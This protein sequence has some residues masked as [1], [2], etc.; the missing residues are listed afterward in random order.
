MDA[1]GRCRVLATAAM[2]FLLAGCAGRTAVEAPGL[3]DGPAGLDGMLAGSGNA[4]AP[5]W[6]V[7]QWWDHHWY[8]GPADTVGFVVKAIV[9]ENGTDG[10]RLATD[11]AVDAASH[12]AFY[13]HDQGVMSPTDW[14]VRDFGGAFQMPYYS[15]P[16]S[17][18]KTWRAQ[19]ENLDFALQRVS[20]QL[21]LTATAIDGT[22]GAFL[23]EARDEA[24]DLRGRWDYQP[25]IGWFSDY[26]LYQPGTQ[27]AEQYSI[28]MVHEAQG[29]GWTGT[30]H[31]AAAD[32]LLNTYRDF[33]PFAPSPPQAPAQFTLT[34]EHT[35]AFV[36]LFSYA[37]AGG[38]AHG[39]LVAPD[40]Q[41]WEASATT[42]PDGSPGPVQSQPFIFVPGVPGDWR[43]AFA[44]ADAAYAGGGCFAFGMR[45][46][47]ATL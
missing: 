34:A 42:L 5:T 28:R 7:G 33:S 20:R 31:L 16:L 12:A 18:G 26:R 1:P 41:H 25:A 4:T 44:A 19:E 36:V 47:A 10:Y 37:V 9:V 35:H 39:Q 23:I 43:F 15:F 21:T 32:F 30:Y 11:E 3:V 24:G 27:D 6:S 40:G 17:D 2:T 46:A 13:F 45:L 29:L 22:P 14:T 38:A 8:F